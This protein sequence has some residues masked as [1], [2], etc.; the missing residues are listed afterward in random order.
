MNKLKELDISGTDISGG[1]EYL[2]ESVEK[3]WCSTDKRPDAKVKVIHS[4]FANEKYIKNF[5]KNF[6]NIKI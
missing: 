5:L 2:P 1:L 3:F 4:L 6:K